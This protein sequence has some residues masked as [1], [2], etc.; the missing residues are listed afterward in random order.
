MAKRR[1]KEQTPSTPPPDASYVLDLWRLKVNEADEARL[2]RLAWEFRRLTRL[3]HSLNIPDAYKAIAKE[4]RTPFVR[5]TWHR[6]VSALNQKPYVV[7]IEPRDQKMDTER[8]CNIGERWDTAVRNSLDKEL[9][10]DTSIESAKAL[11]R[12][13]ESVLKVVH[14]PDAWANFPRREKNEDSESFLN[15]VDKMKKGAPLPFAWRV[16]DRLT[17]VW[18]DGEFG[19]EWVIELA[20]YPRAFM[21]RHYNMRPN[22]EGRL[23][24]PANPLAPIN[25]PDIQ[26]RTAITPANTLGGM[27]KPWGWQNTPFGRCLKAEYLDKDWWAVIVDG[28]MAPGFPKP[29]PYA[30]HLPYFRA[31]GP[32]SESLLYSLLFLVPTLDE[33]LTMKLNW[34]YLGAYPSPVVHAVPNAISG[35]FPTG[36]DGIMPTLQWKPGKALTFPAGWMIDF[37]QPPPVGTDLNQLVEILRGLIDIAGIPSVLRGVGGSDQ[38]GYAI[39]Q[40]MAAASLAFRLASES[41]SRQ[42][43]KAYE[44]LHY[45]VDHRIQQTVYVLAGPQGD[46]Q[47]GKQWIGLHEGQGVSATEA[48]VDELGPVEVTYRVTLPTDEQA[49]AMIAMQIVNAPKPLMSQKRAIEKYLQEEDPETIMDEIAVEEALN[50]SPLRDLW[51]QHAVQQAGLGAGLGGPQNGEPPGA[52]PGVNDAGNAGEP[53]IPGLN[54]PMQPAPPGPPSGGVPGAP[55]GRAAGAFPG[56]PNTPQQQ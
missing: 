35:A 34:S 51:I 4:V 39:N 7:H 42:F 50:T 1:S 23:V 28:S 31:K 48:G 27:P 3:T 36:E 55:G 12:D 49:R 17:T 30:P 53:A 5:D 33:L 14:R 2:I 32:D 20:E 24:D 6:A 47:T 44:F 38:A 56:Q 10:L 18:Q 16:V 22:G 54:Q 21:A 46:N 29:N 43:A 15:R 9:N 25:A 45:L 40:L 19:D 26:A 8:A 41:L 52:Q 13:G 11:I 37:L